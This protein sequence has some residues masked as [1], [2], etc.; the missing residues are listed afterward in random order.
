MALYFMCI[1]RHIWDERHNHNT[2][3]VRNREVKHEV[4]NSGRSSVIKINKAG[5]NISTIK[6]K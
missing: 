6:K 4:R 5:L 1:H 3:H 2:Y